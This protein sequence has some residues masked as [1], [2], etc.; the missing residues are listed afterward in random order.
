MNRFACLLLAI[1]LAG[2]CGCVEKERDQSSAPSEPVAKTPDSKIASNPIDPGDEVIHDAWTRFAEN[3]ALAETNL[4]KKT[5][6]ASGKVMAIDKLP[7]GPNKGKWV[8]ALATDATT[9][10]G[11]TRC[12]FERAEDLEQTGKGKTAKVQGRF[13]SW[14]SKEH[15]LYIKDCQLK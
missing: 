9:K 3:P 13:D 11:F 4:T 14:N 5:L 2:L 7:A 1:A 15:C 6:E 8:L 12:L 10:K